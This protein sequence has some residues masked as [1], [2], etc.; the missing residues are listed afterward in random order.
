M[1]TNALLAKQSAWL[2]SYS[3]DL[4]IVEQGTVISV[5]DGIS[6][7]K[8]LPSAAIEDILIFADGSKG[9]V[10]DL[11]YDKVGAI[12]LYA[13]EHLTAGTTVHLAKH[14]LSVP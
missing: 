4:R 8:G 12:L 11:N 9:M 1:T 7:I 14:P 10:F 6:W 5:G 3:L 2:D 13:S